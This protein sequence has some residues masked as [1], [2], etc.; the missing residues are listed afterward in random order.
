MVSIVGSVSRK[1]FTLER[2][3]SETGEIEFTVT[4]NVPGTCLI[5]FTEEDGKIE[6]SVR[7]LRTK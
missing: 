2:R 3:K 6:Y 1:I 7:M 4:G 5:I